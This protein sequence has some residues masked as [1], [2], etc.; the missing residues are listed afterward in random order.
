MTRVKLDNRGLRRCVADVRNSKPAD[1]R[2]GCDVDDCSLAL[3]LH[4]R[5]HL[6]AGQEHALQV[7]VVNTVPALFGG[8]DRAADFDNPDIVVQH[9]DAAECLETGVNDGSD[10]FGTRHVP[11]DRLADAALRFDDPLRFEGRFEIDIS[12]GNLCPSRANSTAVA[13][14]LPHPGPLDP[15]PETSATLSLSRS[16]MLSSCVVRRSLARHQLSLTLISADG[17]AVKRSRC[18]QAVETRRLLSTEQE[19]TMAFDYSQYGDVLV[20]REDKVLT[21][22]LNSPETLNAFTGP[23]HTRCP[24]SGMM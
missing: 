2:D 1:A 10:I 23:M 17:R 13:L 14:P 11:R 18:R 20:A 24:A 7:N 16:P 5:K 12:C 9:V 19:E 4:V 6:L 3:P 15:A 8:L 21:I 22:T